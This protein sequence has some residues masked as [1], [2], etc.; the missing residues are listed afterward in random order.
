MILD[1]NNYDEYLNSIYWK[2]KREWILKVFEHKCQKCGSTESLQVHHI[3]YNSLGNENQHD[4]TVLCK[5][6]HKE[7]NN[8]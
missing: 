2:E 4:V 3:N 6:C 5:K 1:F 7:V 8:G